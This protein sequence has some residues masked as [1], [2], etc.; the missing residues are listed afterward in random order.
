M[1]A[2]MKR[3]APPITAGE[4]SLL[5]AT[6]EERASCT[7]C[8]LQ[9]RSQARHAPTVKHAWGALS[10]ADPSS[11]AS[12]VDRDCQPDAGLDQE[13]TQLQS[14]EDAIWRCNVHAR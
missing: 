6:Q 14:E 10:G 7:E 13:R 9:A 12:T 4:L 2:W 5:P 3:E 11:D 1:P 8:G